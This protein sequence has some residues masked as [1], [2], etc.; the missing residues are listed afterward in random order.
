MREPV[1]ILSDLHLGHPASK[2]QSVEQLRP[3][4]EGVATVVFNGDTWQELAKVFRPRAEALLDDLQGLC[5]D[6]GVETVFL[7]GNHD[8]GW[9]GKGWVE[10]CEGRIVACHGDAVMWGGSPW[11]REAFARMEQLKVLWAEH[12]EAKHDA[13]ARLMLAR[14][15]ARTLKPPGIPKGRTI[16]RRALDAVNP[17]RRALE[18]LRVWACQADEA[19][20]FAETYFPRAEVLVIGHF[21]HHGI[22]HRRGKLVINTG[23][24][25]NPH[26]ARWV[27][28]RNGMLS[29]GRVEEGEVFRLGPSDGV[30]RLGS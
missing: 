1:R 11:S 6:L 5:A 17:P 16:F 4:L 12:Q 24:Y 13:T 18:I 3:L 8:P 20:K 2:I 22:W 14:E 25:L 28:W 29:C 9:S 10:W 26:G 7:S 19:A 21:H 15:I 27:E 23:A 30:W